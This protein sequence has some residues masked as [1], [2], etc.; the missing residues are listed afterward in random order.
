M[1]R[2]R[3]L[4]LST[5]VL[6]LA[7]SLAAQS[8]QRGDDL[9]RTIGNSTVGATLTAAAFEGYDS[10]T[11]WL[12][13]EARAVA[14]IFGRTAEAG[15]T[16]ARARQDLGGSGSADVCL[17]V[18]GIT[19]YNRLFTGSQNFAAMSPPLSVF[20]G[21]QPTA[22]VTVAGL[23]VTVYV[24]AG[25]LASC[26][27]SVTLQ[28]ASGQATMGASGGLYGWASAGAMIGLPGFGAGAEF[29]LRFA[30]TVLDVN[31]GARPGALLGYARLVLRPLTMRLVAFVELAFMR[32]GEMTLVNSGGAQLTWSLF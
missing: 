9:V 29:Q 14:R 13:C 11:G 26:A 17:R 1:S 32:L 12:D 23:P 2:N 22:T 21:N 6:S 16:R 18:A 4:T 15:Y 31:G 8:A 28:S 5:A 20:A 24:D 10:E 3:S 30:D 19:L 27:G 7:L 25:A